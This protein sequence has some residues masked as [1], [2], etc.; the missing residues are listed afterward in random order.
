MTMTPE[1]EALEAARLLA[2]RRANALGK[3]QVIYQRNRLYYVDT[4][5]R[6]AL[7]KVVEVVE[8]P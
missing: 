6:E 1:N 3:D 7:G 2:K 8:A 5:G 4:V